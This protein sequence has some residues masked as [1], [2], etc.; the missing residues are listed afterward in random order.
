MFDK[1]SSF[2]KNTAIY[3]VVGSARSFIEFFLL[4]LYAKFLTP[5]DFGVLDVIMIYIMLGSVVAILEIT[6]AAFRFYFD[7]DDNQYRKKVMTSAIFSATINS[8]AVFAITLLL[9]NHLSGYFLGTLN[10][11]R[12][13][14]LAGSYILL[15]ASLTLP[16]NLLRIENKAFRYTAVS[17]FQILVSVSGVVVFVVWLKYGVAGILIAKSIAM[18]PTLIICLVWARSYLSFNIDFNLLKKMLKFSLP[19]IPAGMAIWGINGLNRLFML[20]YLTLDQIGLFS[21]A[22]KFTVLITLTVIAFQLAWPQF[23][24]AN[25][26]S[27][28]AAA[29]FGKIFNISLA[30]G[31][32]LVLFITSFSG[33]FIQYAMAAEFEPAIVAVVP[34][35]LGMLMYGLFYFFMTSDTIEKKTSAIVIPLSLAIVTD[36]A[37]N[38]ILTPRFGFLGTAWV[39]FAAYTVM[40]LAMYLRTWRSRFITLDWPKLS[41]LVIPSAILIILVSFWMEINTVGMLIVKTIVF[42]SYPFLLRLTGFINKEN[43]GH[44]KRLMQRSSNIK[45]GEAARCVELQE[46]L[47]MTAAQSNSETPVG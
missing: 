40:A 21:I 20:H 37:L 6:N 36:I 8:L 43:L 33:F 13:F 18:I 38:L 35:S 1:I 27:K 12:L 9:A 17:L 30:L 41:R 15:D 39:A 7:N 10:Y 26:N 4:P 2:L 34:L 31:I 32:W 25:M 42:L 11:S 46:D 23:A 24:F 45:S 5:A 16:L 44:I 14:V 22:A 3:G 47:I 19:L 28:D 29:I